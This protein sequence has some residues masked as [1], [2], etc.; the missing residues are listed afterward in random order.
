MNSYSVQIMSTIIADILQCHLK[1]S[2]TLLSPLKSVG[3]EWYYSNDNDTIVC[4]FLVG[5]WIHDIII[6]FA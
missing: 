5:E 4:L 6:T 2:S 1:Q 3:S